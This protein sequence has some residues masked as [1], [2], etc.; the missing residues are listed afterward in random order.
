MQKT[1][2]NEDYGIYP[3]LLEDGTSTQHRLSLVEVTG[4]IKFSVEKLMKKEVW[5]KEAC[6]KL[7]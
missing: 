4:P 3:N 2:L 5:I 6:V 1:P 7:L